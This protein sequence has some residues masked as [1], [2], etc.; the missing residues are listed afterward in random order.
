MPTTADNVIMGTSPGPRAKNF[1]TS[2]WVD[3]STRMVHRL[4]RWLP[5]AVWFASLVSASAVGFNAS[6]ASLL[7][8][9]ERVGWMVGVM[10]IATIGA[11][12]VSQR[13]SLIP[14]WLLVGFAF[15]WSLGLYAYSLIGL[16]ADSPSL[17]TEARRLIAVGD[18][19]YM[20]ATY[21]LL[22]LLMLVPDGRLPSPR[23]RA[24]PWIL[25]VLVA[26]IAW[27]TFQ[28]SFKVTDVEAWLARSTWASN[29]GAVLSPSDEMAFAVSTAFGAVFLIGLPGFSLWRRLRDATGEERQ[30]VKWIVFAGAAIIAWLLLWIPQ[31]DGGWLATVQ[32]LF[33][34]WA[35]ALF[36][37]GF[38]M[39]LFRYRLWDIDL[40]VRRS[41]IYGVLWLVITAVYVGL[42]SGLGL[43]AG[44]RF[45]IAVAVGLTVVATLVFQPARRWLENVADRWV[46]GARDSPVEAIHSLGEGVAGT[47]RPQDIA[48]ELARTT[49]AALG[50]ARV[51]VV[52]N[53]S[54]N[55]ETGTANS[56]PETIV[57]VAWG[58]ER[59]GSLLCQPHRGRT[60]GPEDLVLLE[61]L[62]GQAALAIS[63]VRLASRIVHAQEDERQRIERNI[64]DGAQQDLA[65]L[66]A[67]LGIARTGADD[68]MMVETLN[69]IQRDAHRVLVEIRELAQGI[70]PSVL[71]DGGVVAA[72]ED[73]CSRL[74][75]DVD[76]QVAPLLVDRRFPPEI[77][78]AAYFF[79]SEAVTN[80]L[81]HSGSDSIDVTLEVDQ[82]RLRI[83][84]GDAGS[85]FDPEKARDGSG[86]DGLSDRIR[87]LGGD[88]IVLSRI[89]RGTVVSAELPIPGE[90]GPS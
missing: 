84:I 40:V 22:L 60:I 58:D 13:R 25:A 37:A 1:G 14:G 48:S 59:F 39:A 30:Q 15:F 28:I 41:L 36:A 4:H 69:R 57:P 66:V 19:A 75:I 31:P 9:A 11:L 70:H 3:A 32:R 50:L 64:H 35:L 72:L 21:A 6:G 17:L 86:L 56:E 79:A 81:K 5:W 82:T 89:G 74:P 53:D 44:S 87:A 88:M 42:A 33:P 67:Q 46:F 62:V 68:P 49:E 47:R 78:A 65:T 34:G 63:H 83:E 73:R 71:R 43:V 76:F 2:G 80:T 90:P 77:E 85:G 45:P 61:A 29:A 24:T 54:P 10:T 8:V 52:M 23:W 51:V 16:P 38:G 20:V 27:Q 18:L 55:A 26:V 7:E 12:A